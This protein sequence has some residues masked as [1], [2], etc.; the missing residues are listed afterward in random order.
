M[1]AFL[2]SLV[3]L[4]FAS[5]AAGSPVPATVTVTGNCTVYGY[6]INANTYEPI[7]S[8]EDPSCEGINYSGSG[9]ISPEGFWVSSWASFA[10]GGVTGQVDIQTLLSLKVMVLGGTG[11]G[12]MGGTYNYET[13]WIDWPAPMTAE[14]NWGLGGSSREFDFN[15]AFLHPF[16]FGEPMLFTVDAR[17]SMTSNYIG[18]SGDLPTMNG[19]MWRMNITDIYGANEHGHIADRLDNAYVAEASSIPEPSAG[20]L[21]G[22]GAVFLA[23]RLK[24]KP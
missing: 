1:Q 8:R 19:F 20:L 21:C 18:Q 23:W 5:A 17:L 24:R 11:Q 9:E 15:H 6:S 4:A 3:L 12:Y 10:G 2:L 22:L 7:Y 14:L 13:L 16:T